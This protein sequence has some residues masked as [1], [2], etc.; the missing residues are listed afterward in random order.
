MCIRDSDYSDTDFDVQIV[1]Q[2]WS[3]QNPLSSDNM[4]TAFDNC[5]S[6]T[7]DDSIWRNTS[8]MATNTPYTSGNLSTAWVNT[9]G[10]TYYSLRSSRDYGNGE[11]SGNEFVDLYAAEATTACLLYTSPEQGWINIWH[12]YTPPATR[13]PPV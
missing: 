4:G 12:S 9:N 10:I 6:A 2:D 5:L 8:G 7:A 11:P 3:G 13:P 1:K